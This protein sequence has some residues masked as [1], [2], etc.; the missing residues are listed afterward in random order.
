ML[1]DT[2]QELVKNITNKTNYLSVKESSLPYYVNSFLSMESSKRESNNI[3]EYV[4]Y[5]INVNRLPSLYKEPLKELI[6]RFEFSPLSFYSLNFSFKTGFFYNCTPKKQNDEYAMFHWLRCRG[7]KNINAL[8][9]KWSFLTE[10]SR[11]S[12]YLRVYK[13]AQKEVVKELKEMK[14]LIDQFN[15]NTSSLLRDLY[16]FEKN[17]LI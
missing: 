15:K 2:L 3:T 6:K 13:Y 1:S 4:S 12:E 14:P 5:T 11:T 8:E 17:M 16:N 9:L 7:Y 10:E